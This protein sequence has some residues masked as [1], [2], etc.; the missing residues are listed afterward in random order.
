MWQI[1]LEMI[2]LNQYIVS[3]YLHSVSVEL[4]SPLFSNARQKLNFWPYVW[5]EWIQMSINFFLY[6]SRG[7]KERLGNTWEGAPDA[8]T[9]QYSYRDGCKV[10]IGGRTTSSSLPS[11]TRLSFAILI[12][13][14]STILPNQSYTLPSLPLLPSSPQTQ[15]P[16][17]FENQTS[18]TWNC[19]LNKPTMVNFW[20]LLRITTACNHPGTPS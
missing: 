20:Q 13:T 16:E 2:E 9:H 14:T 1:Q 17:N 10:S 18:A 3:G 19:K 7:W 6:S 8:R 5:Y 12:L 4:T 15:L 11:L